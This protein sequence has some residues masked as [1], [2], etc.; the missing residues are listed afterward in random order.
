MPASSGLK[1]SLRLLS[2]DPI[3]NNICDVHVTQWVKFMQMHSVMNYTVVYCH[4]CYIALTLLPENP[5]FH[6]KSCI[7]TRP[8][9]YIELKNQT[10]SF[11]FMPFPTFSVWF[12]SMHDKRLIVGSWCHLRKWHIF[13]L[14][15]WSDIGLVWLWR[16]HYPTPEYYLSLFCEK[17]TVY[18]ISVLSQTRWTLCGYD[19]EKI[20]GM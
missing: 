20:W 6:E 12:L 8:L 15:I 11:D 1:S 17:D 2:R 14:I 16:K 3:G 18:I 10:S 7:S 4:F 9:Y 5:L 13:T 19:N